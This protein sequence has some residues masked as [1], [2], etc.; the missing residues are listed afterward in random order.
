[1]AKKEKEEEKIEKKRNGKNNKDKPKDSILSNWTKKWIKAIVMFLVAVI[2][3]LSFPYFDKA[4]Y[5]GELF[6]M[7]C[8]FLIGDVVI[9]DYDYIED[10]INYGHVSV[11]AYGPDDEHLQYAECN[12]NGDLKVHYNRIVSKNDPHIIGVLRGTLNVPF[13]NP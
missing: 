3:V 7:A 4:G 12:F 2:S 13:V 5:A 1:M 10:G 6:I 8:N 9:Q 11:V